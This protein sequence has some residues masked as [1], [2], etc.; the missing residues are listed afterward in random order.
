MNLAKLDIAFPF[1]DNAFDNINYWTSAGTGGLNDPATAKDARFLEVAKFVSLNNSNPAW[2]AAYDPATIV[3]TPGCTGKFTLLQ[4]KIA[5]CYWTITSYGPGQNF[6]WNTHEFSKFGVIN[7]LSPFGVEARNYWMNY[8]QSI[9]NNCTSTYN[10]VQV[11][12][13]NQVVADMTVASFIDIPPVYYD[14]G[15]GFAAWPYNQRNLF[16]NG[17]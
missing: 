7:N 13:Q 2:Q 6:W 15:G 1:W 11:M 4:D 9:M 12:L 5:F 10:G 8:T 16:N 14:T 17:R 3:Y